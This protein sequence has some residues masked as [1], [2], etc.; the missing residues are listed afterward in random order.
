MTDGQRKILDRAFL[1]LGAG[2]RRGRSLARDA[3]LEEVL[4]HARDLEEIVVGVRET[5]EISAGAGN[6]LRRAKTLKPLV[7]P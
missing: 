3:T 1:L 7:G 4:A 6:V 2:A 5:L